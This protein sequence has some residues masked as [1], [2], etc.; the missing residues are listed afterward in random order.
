MSQNLFTPL[1]NKKIYIHIY[2]HHI[3]IHISLHKLHCTNETR[4]VETVLSEV[5]IH[6][7]ISYSYPTPMFLNIFP[8]AA[9]FG[10][11]SKFAAHLDQIS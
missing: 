4:K 2:T 11:F 6:I 10:T 8:L 1:Y 7:Y 9:H 5:Y 3:Y